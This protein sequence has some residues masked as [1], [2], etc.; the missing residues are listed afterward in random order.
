MS[1]AYRIHDYLNQA[2]IEVSLEEI[3]ALGL[4]GEISSRSRI[5]PDG[6]RVFVHE[7]D[8]FKRF[9]TARGIRPED[10]PMDEDVVLRSPVGHYA[11][12]GQGT[13]DGNPS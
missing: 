6:E 7:R 5:S 12:Y 11:P 10:L 13:T 1:E 4:A 3:K 2:W 9:I 8:D